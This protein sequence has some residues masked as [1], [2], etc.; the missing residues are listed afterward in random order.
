MADTNVA[1]KLYKESATSKRVGINVT[2]S[3]ASIS[4]TLSVNGTIGTNDNIYI[5]NTSRGLYVKDSAGNSYRIIGDNGSNLWIGTHQSSSTHHVGQTFISS[6]YNTTN[7]AGNATIYVAVPNAANTSSSA[8]GVYHTGYKPTYSDVG[9]AAASH[10]HGAG[11]ITSGTLAVARG[12]TGKTTLNDAANALLNELTTG[13]SAPQ[14]ADYYISQYAG[15]GTT[16]TTFHR[17]PVS[18]L[19][20]YIKGKADSTYAASSHTHSYAASPAVG[21]GATYVRITDTTPT[22]NTTY[23]VLYAAGKT[24]GSDY[25]VRANAGLYYY[26]TGTTSYL[27]VGDSSNMGGI[28]LHNNG[29]YINIEPAAAT[30]NRTI[31]LPNATGTVSLVGH[32]HAAGDIASGSVAVARGGTGATTVADARANLGGGG[33]VLLYGNTSATKITDNTRKTISTSG[34]S[35]YSAYVVIGAPYGDGKS[36]CTVTIPQLLVGTT[37]VT[38]AESTERW[39]IADDANFITFGFWHSGETIYLQCISRK[40]TSSPIYAVYGIY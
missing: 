34:Y 15:G 30:A 29:K 35:K 40:V 14:D 20:T 2:A 21:G 19:W 24:S 39:C 36:R 3:T 11:D 5:N 18:A 23:Y 12:G 38:D 17:R 37:A 4:Y 13:S 1:I 33:V 26:D 27:N 31:T 22:S 28:T 32:T 6:G 10:T 25:S 8:Y 9:A 7:G 16:Y